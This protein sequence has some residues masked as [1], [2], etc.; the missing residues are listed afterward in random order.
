MTDIAQ[1][2]LDGNA[3]A[4]CGKVVLAPLLDRHWL[5][6]TL[7]SPLAALEDVAGDEP[8]MAGANIPTSRVTARAIGF[9]EELGPG[10]RG[11][12]DD[13]L[14]NLRQ[15]DGGYRLVGAQGLPVEHHLSADRLT[16]R[17]MQNLARRNGASHAYLWHHWLDS[18]MG[19]LGVLR[20]RARAALTWGTLRSGRRRPRRTD[21]ITDHEYELWFPHSYFTHLVRERPAPRAYT[22]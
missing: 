17:E 18:D 10:A 6:P 1:P 20:G 2:I 15:K 8:V 16:D 21:T 4:V 19:L 13:V 11:F 7:R 14:S 22:G 12:A 9:D 5:T 3:D